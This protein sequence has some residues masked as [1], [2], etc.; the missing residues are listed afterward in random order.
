MRRST[1]KLILIAVITAVLILVA[2]PTIAAAS[3]DMTADSCNSSPYHEK[4]SIPTCCLTADCLLYNCSL[5][6]A[7]DNKVLLTS[8]FIPNKNVYI[9]LS[10]TSVS[11][12][13]SPNPKKPLQRELSWE[14][15]SHPYTEYHCRNCLDSE[16]PHQI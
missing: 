3:M 7:A 4:A 10:K 5:S 12:E 1:M 11:N 15:P 6:N 9:A 14:L 16:D 8:R 2:A 13:T